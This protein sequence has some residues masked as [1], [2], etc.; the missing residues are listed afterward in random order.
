M[1]DVTYILLSIHSN[2]FEAMEIIVRIIR[3]WEGAEIGQE[4]DGLR[5]SKREGWWLLQL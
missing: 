3:V 4:G 2:D 1:R 5:V